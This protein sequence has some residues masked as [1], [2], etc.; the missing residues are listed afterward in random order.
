M[1]R[2]S[3]GSE[4]LESLTRDFAPADVAPAIGIPAET[5]VRI[6]R[7]F[8]AAPSA[9]AYGRIGICQQELGT[10]TSWLIDVLNL[11]T[12]NLDR[13]GGAMFPQ[14]AFDLGTL[15]RKVVNNHH[16]R[17]RSR[18][19]SVAHARCHDGPAER[20]EASRAIAAPSGECSTN[21]LPTLT[22]TDAMPAA[23]D[24]SA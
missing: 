14:P 4:R 3:H 16:G 20:S 22:L 10:T 12:G 18:V 21:S 8:A 1:R 24:E 13:E 7:E 19:Q 15:S 6:A 9:V 11:L 5:I 2:R 23:C 17:W